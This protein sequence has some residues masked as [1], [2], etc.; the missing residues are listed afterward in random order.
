[1]KRRVLEI[2]PTQ[3]AIGMKE[4][5]IRIEKLKTMRGSDLD[6]YLHE[7]KIPVVLGPRDRTYCVDHH[8]LLRACWEIGVDEVPVEVVSDLSSLSFPAFWKALHD[9]HWIFLYDQ[10]GNGPHDP[11][12]LPESIRGLADDAFRSLAWLVREK[13]GYQKADVPFAEFAWATFFRKR[14]D[15]HPVFDHM[16]G[17]VQSALRLAKHPDAAHLPGYIGGGGK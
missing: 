15:I 10:F 5:D 1:M 11:V 6:D 12:Q 16:E 2:R 14:L 4:V 3:M 9:S 7:K 13:G 17:A 8:H